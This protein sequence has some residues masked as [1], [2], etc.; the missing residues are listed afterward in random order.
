MLQ[1]FPICENSG[2][3]YMHQFHHRSVPPCPHRKL[4]TYVGYHSPSIIKYMEPLTGDLFTIRYAY[5]I[6][7][8]DMPGEITSTIQNAR[9]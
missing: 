5:C 3:R 7:N 2:V 1:A 4:G 6:F 9:K 8:E